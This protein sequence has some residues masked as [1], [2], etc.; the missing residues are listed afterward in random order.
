MAEPKAKATKP[1]RKND[2]AYVVFRLETTD[3]ALEQESWIPIMGRDQNGD[4]AITRASTRKAA[5]EVATEAEA[6]ALAADGQEPRS[7][8]GAFAVVPAG[9]FVPVKRKI[10]VKEI[11]EFE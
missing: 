11:S 8:E 1:K 4:L 3:G 10:R 9:E 7:K 6:A 5:V 2:P